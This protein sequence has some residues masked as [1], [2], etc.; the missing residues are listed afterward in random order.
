MG[1]S[2]DSGDGDNLGSSNNA[3]QPIPPGH[4]PHFTLRGHTLWLVVESDG[5]GD[6]L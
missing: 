1:R 4:L 2:L 3:Y 5:L 6:W